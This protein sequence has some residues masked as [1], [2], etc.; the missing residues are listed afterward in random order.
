MGCGPKSYSIFKPKLDETCGAIRSYRKLNIRL[1]I[2]VVR[3]RLRIAR[4]HIKEED[5]PHSKIDDLKCRL[6]SPEEP[7][8]H[9]LI[10]E[11]LEEFVN[12]PQPSEITEDRFDALAQFAEIA[13]DLKRYGAI[14]TDAEIIVRQFSTD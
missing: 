6:A 5:V 4:R 7:R 10:D 14:S 9:W 12:V 3:H 2:L 1:C 11:A 8:H 13:A